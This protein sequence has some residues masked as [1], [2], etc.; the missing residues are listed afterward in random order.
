MTPRRGPGR[1]PP[2]EPPPSSERLMTRRLVLLVVLCVSVGLA[3]ADTSS[4]SLPRSTPEAQGVS[5]AGLLAFV[6]AA[7]AR[8]TRC[9]A[10]CWCATGRSSP[11]AGGRRTRPDE[12]H[13]LFSLSKS[14]TS[15]AVGLAVA[16]GQLSV[17]DSVLEASSPTT[18]QRSRAPTSARC[19]CATCSRCPP[20]ITRRTSATSRSRADENLREALPRPAGA[21]QAGHAVRLQHAGDLHAVGHRAEGDGAAGA[22]TT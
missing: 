2:R 15:T 20:D 7:E 9:T 17:D 11:R 1:C 13:M 21:A 12:P 5:S 14:F 6:E 22:S 4:S 10:S 3:A 19:A 8:S 16:E 18:R